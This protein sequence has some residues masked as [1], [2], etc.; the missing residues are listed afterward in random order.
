LKTSDAAGKL[1]KLAGGSGMELD[2]LSGK[3]FRE[4]AKISVN[5]RQVNHRSGV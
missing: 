1:D 2:K 5:L 3:H 4:T